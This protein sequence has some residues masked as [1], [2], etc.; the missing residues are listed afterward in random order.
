MLHDFR[1]RRGLYMLGAGASAG[2]VP[3]GHALM[4]APALDYLRNAGSFP[5][6]VPEKAALT[7]RIV[8]AARTMPLALVY[9][10]REIRTGTDDLIY[11]ELIE[12]LPDYH[13]RHYMKH[14][15]SA[16]R[17]SGRRS[18]NYRVFKLFRRGMIANYNHDGLADD[19]CRSHQVI[20]MHGTI[21]PRFG[22]PEMAEFIAEA[23][24]YDLR[25]PLDDLLM[26][27]PESTWD[28]RLWRRLLEVGTF[29]PEVITVIGYSFGRGE[30]G[31][32]DAVS[33]NLFLRSFRNF[34]GCIYVI[35]PRPYELKHLLA[36]GLQSRNVVGVPAYWNVLAH[37]M[38]VKATRPCCRKS[39]HYT[40]ER[41]LDDF[42]SG[43]SFPRPLD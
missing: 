41:I 22:S 38:V 14:L 35:D 18:D 10:G 17:F 5:V 16:S 37:A 33:L 30:S 20:Q 11:L 42:G 23:R 7:T 15:L 24:E 3:F 32:D 27:A 43:V 31:F 8:E 29:R 4:A 26:C 19:I 34:P 39:L 9:P 1:T 40:S 25:A 21:S 13:A 6:V 12:R 28:M 36:D 2:D